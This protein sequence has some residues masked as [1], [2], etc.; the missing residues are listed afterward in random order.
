MANPNLRMAKRVTALVLLVIAA[1][2]LSAGAQAQSLVSEKLTALQIVM[3]GPSRLDEDYARGM[4]TQ[5]DR[6]VLNRY[7]AQPLTNGPQAK[8]YAE[9]YLTAQMWFA[10]HELGVEDEYANPAGLA[11]LA[12]RHTELLR[13]E[14]RVLPDN[15]GKSESRLELVVRREIATPTSQF[16]NA[17]KAAALEKLRLDTFLSG[18]TLQGLLLNAYGWWVLGGVSIIVGIFCLIASAASLAWSFV[19]GKSARVAPKG[20]STKPLLL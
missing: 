8:A 12:S 16:E 11:M 9:H 20:A 4:L 1:A 6:G 18:T 5:E 19:S 2:T 3:P 14:L 13:A 15:V 17:R 7:A 10:A